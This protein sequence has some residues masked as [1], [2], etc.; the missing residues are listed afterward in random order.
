M[1]KCLILIHALLFNPQICPKNCEVS[2]CLSDKT[3]I[4]EFDVDC[5][6]GNLELTLKDTKIVV[7]RLSATCKKA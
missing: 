4:E 5:K 6:S 7:G 2:F 1:T 3:F